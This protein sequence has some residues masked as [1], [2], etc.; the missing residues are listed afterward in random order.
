MQN[1][2]KQLLSIGEAAELLGVSVDTLR[3]WD[4]EKILLPFRPSNA[5]KRYYRVEDINDFLRRKTERVVDDLAAF[6][7]EWVFSDKPFSINNSLYCQTSDIFYACMYRL[8]L[9]TAKIVGH[10]LLSAIVGEIGNNSYNHNLGNWPDIQGI[11]FGYD[12]SKRQVVLADRGQGIYQTI[13]RVLPGVK[14]DQE[15]LL[16]AFTKYISG[17]APENRG[18]GLKFVRDVVCRNPF[19]LEFYSGDA[20]VVI[21]QNDQKLNIEKNDKNFHGCL[22]IIKF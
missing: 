20:K 17:R 8:D 22:A 4:E 12:L 19:K 21:K 9:E 3:R 11:F 16:V 13:K 6:A 2:A 7:K 18:N 15:A 5:T 14:N 1:M 10:S